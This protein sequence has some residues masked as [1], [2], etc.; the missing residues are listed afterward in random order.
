MK[1]L[2]TAFLVLL[3]AATMVRSSNNKPAG[4][5]SD[6][7]DG[8]RSDIPKMICGRSTGTS[9]F[10]TQRILVSAAHVVSGEECRASSAT[11]T[12]DEYHEHFDLAILS[13]RS[14]QNIHSFIISCTGFSPGQTYRGF[15]YA[16]G[17]NFRSVLLVPD[18]RL[19][20]TTY[21]APLT[22]FQTSSGTVEQGMSGGP[23]INDQG[24]AVGFI[25]AIYIPEDNTALG[26]DFR[27][28]PLCEEYLNGAF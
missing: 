16:R 4:D 23:I 21:R 9:F 10:V 27:Q 6:F 11:F 3:M 5:V 20:Q 17:V 13:T 12:V 19:F 25:S 14:S 1:R 28:T 2:V 8:N 22:S 15:G 18:N 7:L 26:V 24:E